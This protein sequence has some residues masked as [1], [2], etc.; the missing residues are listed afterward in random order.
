MIAGTRT[1]SPSPLQVSCLP[2][3][4]ALKSCLPGSDEKVCISGSDVT[5]PLPRANREDVNMV[6]SSLYADWTARQV[7]AT[8]GGSRLRDNIAGWLF[9]RRLFL[10]H[11]ADV[12]LRPTPA[13]HFWHP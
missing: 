3:P 13:L 10:F 8:G 12:K 11:F 6:G 4:D 9:V 5:R 7:P 1:L 2:F